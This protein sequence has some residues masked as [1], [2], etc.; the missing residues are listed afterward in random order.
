MTSCAGTCP[1]YIKVTLPVRRGVVMLEECAPSG[2]LAASAGEVPP[3]PVAPPLLSPAAY[4]RVPL[5]FPCF[6]AGGLPQGACLR[7]YTYKLCSLKLHVH[8][9]RVT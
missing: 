1:S 6:P 8:Q 4:L 7:T 3:R 2:D 5:S 9:A